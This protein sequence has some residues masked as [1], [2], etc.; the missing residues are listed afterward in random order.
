MLDLYESGGKFRQN[1]LIFNVN[2]RFSSRF[3]LFGFYA[4]GHAYT[5]V[6]GQP[7]NP[8]IFRQ[9]WGRASYDIRH[10]LNINGSLVLPLGLRLSPN[11]SLNS[12]PPSM[13][14]PA[15]TSTATSSSTPG[16]RSCRRAPPRLVDA[17]RVPPQ[18]R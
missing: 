2:S 12:A 7:S 6:S 16:R 3:T 4:F 18:L 13:S 5:D 14:R 11:I 15:W 10:R 8:T 9:D 1:Q 17:P